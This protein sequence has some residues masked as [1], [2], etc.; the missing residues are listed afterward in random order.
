MNKSSWWTII[1]AM[2]IVALALYLMADYFIFRNQGARFTAMDGQ[3]LCERV[4]ALEKVP[5]PCEYV[6]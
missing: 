1:Q 2:A 4:R 6:R 5:M 3:V